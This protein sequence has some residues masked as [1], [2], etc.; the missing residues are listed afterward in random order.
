MSDVTPST[1]TI[2]TTTQ[3][4][5]RRVIICAPASRGR[6]DDAASFRT[7][8]ARRL[9][10]QPLATSYDPAGSRHDSGGRTPDGVANTTHKARE[11]FACLSIVPTWRLLLTLLSLVD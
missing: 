1:T 5:F 11:S 10:R 8:F 9:T 4:R 6:P 7:M 3:A 2:T